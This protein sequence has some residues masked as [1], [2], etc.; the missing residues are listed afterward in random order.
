MR[1]S[2]S[3]ALLFTS[4]CCVGS[5]AHAQTVSPATLYSFCASSACVDGAFTYPAGAAGLIQATN[6][7]LYGT[8]WGGGANGDGTVF[9]IAPSGSL[10]TLYSFCASAS[11]PDGSNP[12]F[13]LVL[14]TNGELYGITTAGGA[15]GKGTVFK[16]TPSGTLAT[17]HSFCADNGCAD[18]SYPYAGLILAANGDLYGTTKA[19]GATGNGTVFEI[20]PSGAL[21]TLYSFSGGADGNAPQAPLIQAADANLYGTT[22]SGGANGQGTVFKITP[23]GGKLTTLY[24]FSGSDGGASQQGL[25]QA[26]NGNLYGAS[27]SGGVSGDGTV[28]QITTSGDLTTLYSFSGS[29]GRSPNS[30]LIQATD[31][32]LYGTTETGGAGGAGTI[33]RITP[34]GELTT[35]YGFSGGAGSLYAGLLEA[36]NGSLYGTTRNGGSAGD[37]TVFRLPVDLGPFV[38]TLPASGKAGDSIRIL[39]YFTGQPTGVAFNGTAAAFTVVSGTEISTV[40]PAGA[41]TGTVEVTTP[42][43]T[44]L[45]NATFSVTPTPS[46]NG[47]ELTI[48]SLEIGDGTYTNVVVKPSSI[49]SVQMGTPGSSVDTYEPAN[50]QLTLPLV[51]YAGTTYTNVVI[52]VGS[53]VS[54]GS[55]TGVD[56][57]SDS[58]L[59]IP[60]VQALGGSVYNNVVITVGGIVSTGG[61]MPSNVQDVYDPAT[62]QLTIAAVQVGSLVYTNAIITVGTIVRD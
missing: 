9:G 4:L 38:E 61:G 16:I 47:T 54:V 12:Y 62:R 34:G 8:T 20:T 11:C 50:N 5:F 6:G 31:G 44:L 19:G 59:S 57:Y 45:S 56:T 23:V 15:S 51:S 13:G 29:D 18:G 39:G 2:K 26:A 37:G 22:H 41:T 60:S 28:F 27:K 10:I 7:G 24:S 49:V 30:A 33:F 3:L 40:V 17:L 32:N 55:V 52:T 35:L 53:L 14:A 58:Q 43:G 46:Y 48:P 42:G 25:V 36:T 1:A 21:T